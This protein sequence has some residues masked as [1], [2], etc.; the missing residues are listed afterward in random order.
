MKNFAPVQPERISTGIRGMDDVL[1]GGLP[2]HRLYLL[3]GEPGSGKTTVGL[4]FLR[5][6][7]D[8]GEKVLYVTLSESEEELAGVAS[9]HGWTLDG[10]EMFE[11]G[12]SKSLDMSS[13]Q[14][15]LHPSELELS[16]T[17]DSILEC[18]VRL[19][20][21]RL[22]IDSLSELRLLAQDSLR[23]RHEH[24]PLRRPTTG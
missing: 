6:G 5:A 15:V 22:V 17:T 1:D 12:S 2:A 24:T 20:P 8:A 18:V 23:Y 16:E 13:D 7:I 21:D 10:I 3:E 19:E 14:S 4:Q 11:L 9:S